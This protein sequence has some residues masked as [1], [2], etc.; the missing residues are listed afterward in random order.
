MGQ[1][2]CFCYLVSTL[3][4]CFADL[5]MLDCS[6]NQLKDVPAGLSQ[7]SALEQLYLRHNKLRLLPHLSSPVLQ[8]SAALLVFLLWW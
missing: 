4:C 1:R 8:V 5:K 3:S 7:M 2:R 6:S